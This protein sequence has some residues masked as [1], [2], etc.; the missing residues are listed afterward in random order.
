MIQTK[1]DNVFLDRGKISTLNSEPNRSVYGER[2]FSEKGKEYRQWDPKRS[3]LGT[4]IAKNLPIPKLK[5]TDVWLYLGSASGTT[6]SHVSDIVT[7]GIIFALD[8]APRVLRDL[9]FLSQRRNNI[10]PIKVDAAQVKTFAPLVSGVDVVFQDIAQR[11][12]VKTFLKNFIFL[13]KS[14]TGLLSLKA[15]SIDVSKK[16]KIIFKQVERELKDAGVLVS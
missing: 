2:R 10:A 12:Q 13:K 4:A 8:F 3:K 11:E 16:P 9:Y 1:H 15:P 6:V 14:S 7:K 5:E